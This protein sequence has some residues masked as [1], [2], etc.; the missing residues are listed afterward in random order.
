MASDT[1]YRL[2][3]VMDATQDAFVSAVRSGLFPPGPSPTWDFGLP[4]E[5]MDLVA[6]HLAAVPDRDDL[7]RFD[8]GGVFGDVP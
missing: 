3:N 6:G 5:V 4:D 1:Y 2:L 8:R 7:G